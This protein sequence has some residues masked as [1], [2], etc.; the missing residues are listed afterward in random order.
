MKTDRN[1]RGRRDVGVDNLGAGTFV[2]RH[3]ASLKAGFVIAALMG[4][5]S[6][7][8]AQTPLTSGQL[9]QIP[10]EPVIPAPAPDVDLAPRATACETSPRGPSVRVDRLRMTGATPV[11]PGRPANR[12]RLRPGQGS[13]PRRNARRR[14]P[15]LRLLSC[16]G[17]FSRAGLCARAGRAIGHHR[18]RGNRGPLWRRRP[19]QRQP[20][21]RRGRAGHPRRDRCGR[22]R[23]RRAA[24]APVAAPVRLARRRRPIDAAA[25]LRRRHLGPDRRPRAGPSRHRQRRGGQRGQSLH[26]RLSR[27][28]HGQPQQPARARRT[29]Q[30]THPAS[31]GGLA[32]GRASYQAP[33]AGATL[34]IAYTHVRYRLGRAFERLDADGTAHIV[35]AHAGYPLV[36]SRSYNLHALGTVEPK[37]FEDRIGPVSMRSNKRSRVAT[38]GFAADARDS[39]SGGGGS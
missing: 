10:P 20:G 28:R 29:V 15:G 13:H 8:H 36:R 30:R 33:V 35:G 9:Q 6:Y 26:R 38:V 11:R 1:L 23:R 31:S 24:G 21:V 19:D 39:G 32:Y 2:F 17:V 12:D 27:R 4:T 3:Q 25:G 14:R 34:G 18:D 37:W 5:T 7:A 22:D 16:A